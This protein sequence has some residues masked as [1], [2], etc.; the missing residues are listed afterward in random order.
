VLDLPIN[1]NYVFGIDVK[2]SIAM[3]GCNGRLSGKTI[4]VSILLQADSVLREFLLRLRI[5]DR[6]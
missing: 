6:L 1:S 5:L 2:L 4:P 3:G